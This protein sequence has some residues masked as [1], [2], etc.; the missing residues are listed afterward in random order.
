VTT[1]FEC[2]VIDS[3]DP[4]RV[5]R[6]WS[7]ATGWEIAME[8]ADDVAVEPAYGDP[9]GIPLVFVPVPEPK[10]GK[11]RI[12]LDLWSGTTRDQ[13]DAVV[14]LRDLGA[15]PVDIG[16]GAV[17]WVVLTDPEGNELCVLEPRDAYQDT[18][19][20]AAV[21]LDAA[22]P[23]ARA[24]FWSAATG[25]PVVRG[26]PDYAALRAPE[27]RGPYIELIGAS[28]P[29]IVKNRMH[30]DVAPYADGDHAAEVARLTAF[31]ATPVDIGQ[32]AVPWTV[33]ADPEG[34]EFCV[35]EPR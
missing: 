35:L 30:I 12:H 32:G 18:G 27:G 34:N 29:K 11:N 8:T 9:D 28:D 17:P 3:L 23:T 10:T 22:A 21:V 24:A 33:L 16:Q 19:P 20:V 5:A 1:R 14:R 31:G 26:G 6:F 4:L 7:A 2:V 15:V 25:W 13:A